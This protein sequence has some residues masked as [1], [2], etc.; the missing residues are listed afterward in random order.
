MKRLNVGTRL[1]K[2]FRVF[3]LSWPTLATVELSGYEHSGFVLRTRVGKIQRDRI[4]KGG[5][6]LNNRKQWVFF[7]GVNYTVEPRFKKNVSYLR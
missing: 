2:T 6:T 7:Y 3:V 1:I 5:E 4:Q